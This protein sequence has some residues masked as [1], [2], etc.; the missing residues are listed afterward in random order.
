MLNQ[1]SLAK[2]LGASFSL[3]LLLLI[4]VS[5]VSFTTI[6]NAS[7]DFVNYRSL[8]RDTNLMG[9]VQANML[10]IR[11]NVKDFIITG[12]DKDEKQYSDF[13][14][15]TDDFL[16][17]AQT[18]IQ[19]KERAKLVDLADDSLDEYQE[20]FNLVVEAKNERNRLVYDIL[21]KKGPFME[22]TL[23]DILVSAEDDGDVKAAY[24][25]ALSMK[26]LLLA[27]LYMAKFLD[28]NSE[29]NVDQVLEEFGKMQENLTILEKELQNSQRRQWLAEVVEAKGIY[30]ANFNKLVTVIFDRNKVIDG[31]LD[32]LGPVIAKA[33][34]DTKL[35]VKADQDLLG[36]KLQAA[37]DR[38][39]MVIV[40]LSLVA[41]L[42]GLVV[43]FIVVKGV[44]AQLGEDPREISRIA[45]LLGKGD[46]RIEFNKTDVKGVYKEIKNTVDNLKQV[47]T[48]VRV[49][50]ENV[51]S[52]SMQLSSTAQQ[53]SQGA[54]EQASA[55]EETT[56]SMEQM[57][58]NIEQNADNSTQT[59]AISQKAATD[60]EESGSA[61]TEAVGAMKE[62][63]G[64]I[65]IIEEI[66][67]QT[68]LLALNA[69]IEAARAGE[70]GKG[71]AVVAAEVRKLAERSQVAAGEISELS[72][73]SV[74]V[75]ERAGQ[76]LEKLV[77]NIKKT[78]DLVQE[79][80]ASSKEQNSGADQIS[81]AIQQLDQVIQ[82]NAAST[83]EMASTSEELS[84]QAQQLKDTMA[85][86][87]LNDI[88]AGENMQSM[89]HLQLGNGQPSQ[90]KMDKALG[91]SNVITP[92]IGMDNNPRLPGSP[93]IDLNLEE[94]Q[95]ED[96]EFERF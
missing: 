47:V 8:A 79:I 77:P 4:I 10:M 25:S 42:T 76:M 86:F 80:T 38:A 17:Q 56:S 69:A 74:Q 48:D 83:E 68:N 54:S 2:K 21:D 49:A 62:I 92:G 53:L 87:T 23:T 18:D 36:P 28:T 40:I 29:Q 82:Q 81:K 34:E 5:V 66:S 20:G 64:K 94:Q 30:I 90:A 6:E 50:S 16:E 59:E 61:V 41:V 70:H 32:R 15:I 19:N 7:T 12:S 3:V 75:A 11:M 37:N 31:T 33:V 67:R 44:M 89:S 95:K 60:A 14:K 63:A 88:R 51:A 72:A 43:A 55:V 13:V 24:Y 26:R 71:F 58:S 35:S 46:L 85:F 45:Q 84:S 57:S 96:I 93:G 1:I 22:K 9:R 65:S 73:S 52:G 91:G 78:S 27:R 39:V